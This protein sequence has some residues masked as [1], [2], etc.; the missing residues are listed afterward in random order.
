MPDTS[1]TAAGGILALTILAGTIGG[2]VA[3]QA[4]AGFVAGL[5]AGTVVAIV[6]WLRERRRI[7]R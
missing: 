3:G 5:V 4:S 2:A 6:L 7:G 1:P